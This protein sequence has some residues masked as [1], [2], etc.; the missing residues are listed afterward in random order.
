MTRTHRRAWT[1]ALVA[2]AIEMLVSA[3][4]VRA[5]GAG[6]TSAPTSVDAASRLTWKAETRAAGI[7]VLR[8]LSATGPDTDG[9]RT[10]LGRVLTWDAATRA[11]GVALLRSV[12][13][14]TARPDAEEALGEV[15]TW[16]TATR[17]E[18]IDRLRRLQA[19]HPERV[20]TRLKLAEVLSWSAETRDEAESLYRAILRSD[21]T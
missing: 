7:A 12:T 8:Q 4:V 21:T 16:N 5:Q 9:A 11:E 15:L 6:G 19:Q 1:M 14:S 10:E 2:V 20:S 17:P 3:S 13:A 18:G